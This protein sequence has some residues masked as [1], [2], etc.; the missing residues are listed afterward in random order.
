MIIMDTE[1]TGLLKPTVVPLDKQPHI[2]EFAAIKLDDKN[3]Y[4]SNRITFLVNPGIPLEPIITK[5]TGLT[6]KDLAKE[7]PFSAHY[8][9]LVRFFLGEE[10]LIAH[11]APFDVG[12][13]TVE[14]QRLGM[15]QRF[16]WPF[17]HV[18]TVER[19]QYMTGKY[20][21][22]E[23]LYKELFGKDPEQ[24]HRALGDVEILVDVVR[25]LRRQ[26]AI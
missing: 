20:L 16:P 10:M 2:I 3:L 17:K 1:T 22:L 5:I 14:L 12:M 8:L 9:E 15:L 21:K 25:Q 13:L 23:Q 19:T 26:G 11:N 18:C 6:D 4:E 24:K 7:Q